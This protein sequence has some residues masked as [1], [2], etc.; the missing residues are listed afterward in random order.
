[1]AGVVNR[2]IIL[3]S[4]P[5]GIPQPDDFELVEVPRQDLGPGELL[6]RNIYLS[7]DPAQKGWVS[8]AANYSQPVGLGEVMRA[9]TVGEVVASNHQGYSVGEIVCGMLGWQ[10]YAL[11]DGKGIEHRVD[12][13]PAPISTALGVL[14]HTGLTAYFALLDIGQ[15][16][17]GETVVVSTAAGAVGSVVGQ[18]A[19]I[20]GCRT[21]GL[22]GSDTKV[23]FCLNEFGYDAALNYKTTADLDS[24]LEEACADGV[25]VFFDNTGGAISDAVLRHISV[26]ARIVICGTAATASWDPPPLG[27]RVDRRLLVNRARMQGFLLFDYRDRYSEGLTQMTEWVRQGRI[28]YR[29]DIVDGLQNAPAALASLYEGKNKGKLLIRLGSEPEATA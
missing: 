29:E 12:P 9:F 25:N 24:A 6:I 17:S 10:E 15:P 18:I 22:T 7:V 16:R 2:R 27:P 14:G 4:R 21:V 1:M 13:L 23:G 8:A 20:K 28:K 5:S 19:K 11:S 26:G 3:K